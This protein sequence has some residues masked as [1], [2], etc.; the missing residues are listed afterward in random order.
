MAPMRFLVKMERKE[1]Q[2]KQGKMELCVSSMVGKFVF[3]KEIEGKGV[4]KIV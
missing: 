1:R 2:G 4:G 3:G